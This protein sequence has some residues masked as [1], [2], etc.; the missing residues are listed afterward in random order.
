MPILE[1]ATKGDGDEVNIGDL[2]VG[3]GR[4]L[5]GRVILADGKPVA[6]GMR[7]TIGSDSAFDSQTA[8]LGPDGKFEFTGLRD[9]G[10]S[11]FTSVRGYEQGQEALTVNRDIDDFTITLAAKQRP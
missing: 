3:P 9:D 8:L 5:R 4:R 11:V 6:K 1:C 7:V 2:P 10:Y